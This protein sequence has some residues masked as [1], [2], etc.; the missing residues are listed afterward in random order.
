MKKTC[1]IANLVVALVIFINLGQNVAEAQE[2][3]TVLVVDAGV[4]PNSKF[5]F[6]D[7]F[8]EWMQENVFTF[9]V[10][11]LR[12]EAALANASERVAEAQIL[13]ARGLLSSQLADRALL[14]WGKELFLAAR[15]VEGQMEKG[16]NSA[17]LIQQT[18]DIIFSGKEALDEEIRDDI[19]L[20]ADDRERLEEYSWKTE[21]KALML[22]SND[23]D[24]QF[25]PAMEA[26]I[27]GQIYFTEKN[28]TERKRRL[29]IN[30]DNGKIQFVGSELIAVAEK[31][32]EQAKKFTEN[33]DYKNALDE[34]QEVRSA[35][36]LSGVKTLLFNEA[37]EQN[38]SVILERV[39]KAKEIV[40]NSGLLD[41]E[42]IDNAQKILMEQL[43]IKN[44][45]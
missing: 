18:L 20:M 26:L 10:S 17:H 45:E 2:E 41:M 6:L 9:G 40:V 13:S 4:L 15:V 27:K 44:Q 24:M 29:I 16:N 38:S 32:I 3:Q 23:G 43:G 30:G 21:E 5:Y 7:R 42:L 14:E 37:D 11:S 28:V 36:H 39:G 19:L 33:D 35:I 25:E 31:G 34:M 8:D 12:T 22:L 1:L